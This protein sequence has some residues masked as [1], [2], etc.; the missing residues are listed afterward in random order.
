MSIL[1]TYGSLTFKS[2]SMILTYKFV[3]SLPFPLSRSYPQLNSHYL[4]FYRFFPRMPKSPKVR[5]YYFFFFFFC[6]RCYPSFLPS[7][8]MDSFL[9]LFCL[10]CLLIQCNIDF[11]LS[12]AFGCPKF[13]SI[14]HLKFS[15]LR[16]LN[17]ARSQG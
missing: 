8:I 5:L 2:F 7:V 10:I 16:F 14:Q 6:S 9:I 13:R 12:W 1:S 3:S 4:G 17:R 15:V 11:I